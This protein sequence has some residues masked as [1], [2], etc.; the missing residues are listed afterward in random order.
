MLEGPQR[1]RRVFGLDDLE[2]I[3]AQQHR[4]HGADVGLV[5]DNKNA[6][7]RA[8]QAI[9]CEAYNNPTLQTPLRARAF[10][11]VGKRPVTGRR[12]SAFRLVG[13]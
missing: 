9:E 13:L 7:H 11:R 12:L 3:D 1:A 6:W 2:M 10:S 4:D 8:L 5:V